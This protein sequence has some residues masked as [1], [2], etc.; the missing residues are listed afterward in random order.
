MSQKELYT[1]W[2]WFFTGELIMSIGA[3][4]WYFVKA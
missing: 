2:F 3:L 4:I 1:F